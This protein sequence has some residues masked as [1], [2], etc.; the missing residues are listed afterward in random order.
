MV[1]KAVQAFPELYLPLF[2]HTGDIKSRDVLEAV[3]VAETVT[4]LDYPVIVHMKHYI[5]KCDSKGNFK[6]TLLT[7]TRDLMVC[8]G[9]P[10]AELKALPYTF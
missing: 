4:K 2:V 9:F 3:Y 8:S 7:S 1:L 10:S 5:E 6:A